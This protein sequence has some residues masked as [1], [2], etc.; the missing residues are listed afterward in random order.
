M[1]AALVLPPFYYKSVGAAGLTDYFRRLLDAAVPDRWP[2][3][4]YHIPAVSGVPIPLETV[5]SLEQYFPDRLAGIKDS[6]G[7][8]EHTRTA[9][10]RFPQLSIF[11]GSDN[12][13]LPAVEA[14]G[15]G[16]ITALANVVGDVLVAIWS[17]H[18]GGHDMTSTQA[19][20][21]GLRAAASEYLLVAVVKH[22]LAEVHGLPEWPLRPPLESLTR[23]ERQALAAATRQY[24]Y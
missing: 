23:A 19:Q 9:I 22:L 11:T 15:A 14:G 4:L 17:G 24:L 7:D 18:I 2:L 5:E 3:L 10:R 13:V 16:A 12:H 21:A 8:L 1:D 20:L 6:G